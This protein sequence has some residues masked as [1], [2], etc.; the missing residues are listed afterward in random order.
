MLPQP[1]PPC[2][3]KRNTE[4]DPCTTCSNNSSQLINGVYPA[5]STSSSQALNVNST[6]I[7]RTDVEFLKYVVIESN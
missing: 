3:K 2:K 4:L 1:P 6:L 5:G 7:H